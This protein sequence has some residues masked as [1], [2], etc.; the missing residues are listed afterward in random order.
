MSRN[1]YE[2]SY[3]THMVAAI[4]FTNAGAETKC[5]QLQHVDLFIKEKHERVCCWP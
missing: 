5:K 2:H 1:R 4:L 3:A